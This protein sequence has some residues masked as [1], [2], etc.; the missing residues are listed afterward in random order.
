MIISNSQGLRVE[1]ME[2][3]AVKSI[4]AGPVR[5]SM[6]EATPFSRYGPNL[7][8]RKRTDPFGFTPL[9]GPGSSG[10]FSVSGHLFASIGTWEGLEYKVILELSTRETAWQWRVTVVNRTELPV[11]LDLFCIQDAGLKPVTEGSINEY[12]VSQYLEK[13]ILHDNGHGA[14]ICCRQNM[15]GPTGHPWLMMA[16]AGR[17]VAASADGMQ[18]YGKSYRE[19]GKPEG[20]FH[21]VL[22]G[23]YAGESTVLALQEMPFVLAPGESHDFAFAGLFLPDHPE[24]T[25][26]A[27]LGRVPGLMAAFD[28]VDGQAPADT[29]REPVRSLF[30]AATFLP[31]DDLD[32]ADLTHFFGPE[33]RHVE[34]QD[35]R[36]LSFFYKEN[37]HVVMK[38][39]EILADRPHGH[40]IRAKDGCT[41]DEAMVSS[42]CFATG[43]FNSH[44]TQGNTNFSTLL[45]VCS[46]QFNQAPETGQRIIVG[47]GGKYYLLG[48]PS[49]FEMGLNHCR[50]IYRSGDR[51]FQVRTWASVKTPVVNFD[52]RVLE[53]EPVDLF[54]THDFDPLN[55]WKVV[56]G[57]DDRTFLALPDPGSMVAGKFPEARF[58]L[59]IQPLPGNITAGSDDLLSP[60]GKGPG[61]SLFVL[62]VKETLSFGMKFTGEVPGNFPDT[63]KPEDGDRWESDNREARDAWKELS[64]GLVIDSPDPA[65][66]V[67][68]EILPWFGM[69]ALT[70]FLTP[71]GL[72]Q[73]SGAAWGTRDVAQGPFDLLLSM[74]K[75]AEARKVLLI[76]FSNQ[77][78]DGGWPQWWMFDSFSHIRADSAHGDIFYWCLMALANYIRVTGDAEVLGEVLPYY[79]EKGPGEA[80]KTTLSEHAERLIRMII[81]SFIPGTALVPFGGGDWNDSLQP[82]SKDLARRMISSWTVE[83]NFQAFDQF[84]RVYESVGRKDRALELQ[85]V[86]NRIRADFNRHLVRNGVVAGYGLVEEDGTISVLLHPDDARTGIHYSL[87]P[88][89]RGV[90]S[91]IFTTEQA[92][93][94]RTVTDEHLKGPDGA[95]LMDRPLPYRGGIQVI[96][97]RAESSTFFGREIGLMYVHEHLRY[98]ESLARTGRAGEFLAA[99]RQAVPVQYRDAVPCGDI[100]QSNCYY[101]SSDVVFRNRYEA[102]DRYDEI[103][104][105]NLTLRGGWRVY[106]SGPGIFTGLV[107]M[108]LLG[109][110]VESEQIVIDPVMPRRLDGLTT[111]LRL[112]KFPVTLVYRIRLGEFSPQTIHVNGSP[113]TFRYE[114]NPYRAGGAIIPKEDFTRLLNTT[115][116]LIEIGL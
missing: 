7:Y 60:G 32:D 42:T 39:K 55:G 19:T 111:S 22:S 20:L 69:N 66:A 52:F 9:L 94:H 78:P 79:H 24:A 84:R 63:E 12:Y 83:M 93:N 110:R 87:L 40:I 21:D 98:A 57:G 86:C 43:V 1:F 68:R 71:Y 23:E 5:I 67:I 91:G 106:S 105:G 44:L 114:E 46:A 62:L 88:M 2:N 14:V 102:D 61:S 15:Q 28:R 90:I 17:T 108:R 51:L 74:E 34:Y 58:R 25:S 89:N 65:I 53:G 35:N 75:Y 77:N 50:W 81:G 70:H 45:S 13:R 72:E 16:S 112:M 6:K 115:A 92:A 36:L 100:R 113:V 103:I 64:L 99:L 107:L 31:V 33:R 85:E 104:R 56:T 29:P 10:R 59:E 95:R 97:Q 30:D 18:W 101:S 109:L 3:G 26:E 37:N 96:F 47:T 8:L 27:D 80:E 11:E 54:I 41:P 48:L 82:V 38:E 73:F 116:N 76:L 49:A 4:T